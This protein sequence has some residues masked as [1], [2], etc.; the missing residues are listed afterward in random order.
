M[1][2]IYYDGWILDPL[3]EDDHIYRVKNREYNNSMKKRKL[4]LIFLFFFFFF[5]FSRIIFFLIQ[6]LF[7]FSLPIL[8][9]YQMWHL[10][11]FPFHI[12]D[13]FDFYPLH[14]QYPFLRANNPTI[15]NFTSFYHQNKISNFSFN[16]LFSSTLNSSRFKY[17]PLC[18]KSWYKLSNPQINPK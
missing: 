11:I 18:V 12:N 4:F 3:S 6:L 17:P 13:T 10:L 1:G 14:S 9:A 15:Y 2:W 5:F 7:F 16:L 8:F